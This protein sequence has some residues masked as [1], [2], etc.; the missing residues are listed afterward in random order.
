MMDLEAQRA[1]VVLAAVVLVTFGL[2]LPGRRLRSTLSTLLAGGLIG[3]VAYPVALCLFMGL[4][5]G[6]STP[7]FFWDRFRF[8]S[9][10]YATSVTLD[11]LPRGA[12]LGLLVGVF[13]IWRRGRAKPAGAATGALDA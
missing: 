13:V 1:S 6:L 8:A 4:A 9:R 11:A 2:L 7:A 3:G 12:A 5:S 10:I